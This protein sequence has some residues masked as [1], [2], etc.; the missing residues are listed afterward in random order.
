[1]RFIPASEAARLA[2]VSRETMNNRIHKK[3]VAAIMKNG[4]HYVLTVNDDIVGQS[5]NGTLTTSLL[6]KVQDDTYVPTKRQPNGV[7]HW[8]LSDTL[9]LV[10]KDHA[11]ASKRT[12]AKQ[13]AYPQGSIIFTVT[14]SD[15]GMEALNT[16]HERYSD[17][18]GR[19]IFRQGVIQQ[20]IAML[21]ETQFN[22]DIAREWASGYR[23]EQNK[24][25]LVTRWTPDEYAQLERVQSWYEQRMAEAGIGKGRRWARGKPGRGRVCDF[26]LCMALQSEGLTDNPTSDIMVE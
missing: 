25:R 10:H 13:R 6:Q 17:R 18:E 15:R 1:M 9:W 23:L 14:L 3:E 16:L 19:P 11:P 2:G 22:E 26:A 12:T 24:N 7:P 8:Q 20:A 21:D 4:R 5:N